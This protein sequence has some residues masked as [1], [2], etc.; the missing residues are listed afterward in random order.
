MGKY[1]AREVS[2]DY[3]SI[4]VRRIDFLQFCPAHQVSIDG[5]EKGS[6]VVYEIKSCI[7]DVFSGNG[8]NF[9]A[10][11]NYIVTTT[12]TWKRLIP[13]YKNGD[14]TK[15]IIEH[16]PPGSG[17]FGIMVAVPDHRAPEEEFETPT[18]LDQPDITWKLVVV[19]P[20]RDG[21]RKRSMPELLFCMLRA[22]H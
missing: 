5:I 14:L 8:V 9:V 20:C 18:P 13:K 22:G 16:N 12:E 17:H 7:E 10:E 2:L 11:K 21:H 1:W 3:G 6:F 19:V 15:H 4:N